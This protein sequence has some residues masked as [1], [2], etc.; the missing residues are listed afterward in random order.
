MEYDLKSSLRRGV[1]PSI[2]KWDGYLIENA[3]AEMMEAADL[4]EK[5]EL[6][7]KE[8]DEKLRVLCLNTASLISFVTNKFIGED[9]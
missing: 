8:L 3:N 4:I 6:K 5:Q 2:A 9:K 7:I 1:K